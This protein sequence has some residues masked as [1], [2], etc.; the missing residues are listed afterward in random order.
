MSRR[1]STFRQRDL[2]AAIKGAKAAGCAV[3]RV[4]VGKDGKI[5]VIVSDGKEQPVDKTGC[6]NEWD[7][8]L[9]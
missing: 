6:S 4:E 5:T 9:K 1:P 8:I 2:A 7:A 3:T